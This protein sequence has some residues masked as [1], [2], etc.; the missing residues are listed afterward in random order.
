MCEVDYGDGL[1]LRTVFGRI[2]RIVVQPRIIR[3]H[4]F[5]PKC[6]V[7][8]LVLAATGEH[9]AV[10]H[11]THPQPTNITIAIYKKSLW[12][13]LGTRMPGRF[14]KCFIS[15]YVW[16]TGRG[17]DGRWMRERWTSSGGHDEKSHIYLPN[18]C[19]YC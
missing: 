2:R 16:V 10:S 18:E 1:L 15:Q 4:Y 19:H 3:F 9:G 13:C 14:S 11:T 12:E 7:D 17:A 8:I 5:G 6:L